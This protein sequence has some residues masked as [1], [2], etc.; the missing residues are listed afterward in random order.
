MEK[1]NYQKAVAD[2]VRDYIEEN[3]I[4][5]KDY[6]DADELKEFL[7]N[8]LWTAD[9]VT[10]TGRGHTR[11][12]RGKQRRIFATTGVSCKRLITHWLQ[13]NSCERH[14]RGGRRKYTLL[15]VA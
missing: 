13:W 2:D 1:Y 11:S 15:F 9:S 6:K 8:E 3:G 12:A 4:T 10:G 7:Q 14:L 5:L